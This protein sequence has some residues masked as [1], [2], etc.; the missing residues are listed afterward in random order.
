[1]DPRNID[2]ISARLESEFRYGPERLRPEHLSFIPTPVLPATGL[3]TDGGGGGLAILNITQP[4]LIS[5]PYDQCFILRYIRGWLKGGLFLPTAAGTPDGYYQRPS[6]VDLAQITFTVRDEG[7]QRNIPTS[8][9][10]MAEVTGENADAP[11][12]DL[13]LLGGHYT[14]RPGATVRV[15]FGTLAGGFPLNLNNFSTAAGVPGQVNF[16]ISLWGIA[17]HRELYERFMDNERRQAEQALEEHRKAVE[18]GQKAPL[19]PAV[20]QSRG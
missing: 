5:I 17:V 7:A 3:V 13:R 1:M 12:L 9:I 15:T 14:F 19:V 18:A 16:G 8:D 10:P 20:F 11:G 6:P 2:D 4:A